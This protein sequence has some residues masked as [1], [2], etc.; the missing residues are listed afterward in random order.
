MHSWGFDME[1]LFKRFFRRY[2]TQLQLE[3]GQQ[4]QTVFGIFFSVNSRSWQNMERAFVALGEIPRG[5]YI[6]VLPAD[7]A[8]QAGCTVWVEE[9]AYEI[10]R[11]EPVRA[12]NTA[13]YS[14][15]LCVEKGGEDLW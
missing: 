1:K 8:V 13:V 11:A 2:G 7:L 12:G 4:V 6:C 15:C 3:D 9:K 5:Q 10:R 14:W